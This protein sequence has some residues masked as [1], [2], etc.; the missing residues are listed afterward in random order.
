MGYNFY[1]YFSDCSFPK[2]MSLFFASYTISQIVLFGN[3]YYHTYIKVKPNRVPPE[4]SSST[5]IKENFTD[6]NDNIKKGQ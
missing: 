5:A 2:G 3:F 1:N 6:I 4:A